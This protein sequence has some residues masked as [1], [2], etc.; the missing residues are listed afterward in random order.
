MSMGDTMLLFAVST[1]ETEARAIIEPRRIIIGTFARQMVAQQRANRSAAALD[2]AALWH[3]FRERAPALTPLEYE[4]LA[5]DLGFIEQL[6]EVRLQQLHRSNALRIPGHHPQKKAPPSDSPAVAAVFAAIRAVL[7]ASDNVTTWVRAFTTH[8][9]FHDDRTAQ[10]V[11]YDFKKVRRSATSQARSL[12]QTW[13]DTD[14]TALLRYSTYPYQHA[15]ALL[16]AHAQEAV[17]QSDESIDRSLILPELRA[18]VVCLVQVLQDAELN[19]YYQMLCFPTHTLYDESLWHQPPFSDYRKR[20]QER[21]PEDIRRIIVRAVTL[22]RGCDDSIATRLLHSYLHAGMSD[23]AAWRCQQHYPTVQLHLGRG[24]IRH[25]AEQM[26]RALPQPAQ[27]TILARLDA[28]QDAADAAKVSL[29]WYHL[30]IDV[31]GSRVR[32]HEQHKE[33]PGDFVATFATN[34]RITKE[35][36]QALL[37]NSMI[38]GPLGLLPIREWRTL[39]HPTLWSYLHLHK[40]GHL[41]GMINYPRL[42]ET[43]AAYARLLNRPPLPQQ[44]VT[45]IC[46]H[47]PKDNYF[48][49]GDGEAT[50]GVPLRKSLKLAGVA[51]LHEEWLVMAVAVEI[52]LVDHT[53][54]SRNTECIALCVFDCG[55]QR[56]VTCCVYAGP[57]SVREIG[58]TLYDA[59]WHPHN[60]A[61]PLR[62]LPEHILLPKPLAQGDLS[63]IQESAS[64]MHTNVHEV[65]PTDLKKKLT[66]HAFIKQTIADLQEEYKP[67]RR[68]GRRR[69]PRQQM[70]VMEAQTTIR[71]WLHEYGF[72]QDHRIEHEKVPRAIRDRG[73]IM[74]GFDTAVAGYLLP[75]VATDV[76][77]VRDGVEYQQFRYLNPDAEIEPGYTVTLRAL[78]HDTGRPQAV[79]AAYGNP[80]CLHYLDLV[81]RR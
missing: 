50:A 74:P 31:P 4:P 25:A 68:S 53:G 66:H 12:V 33:R 30:V 21:L 52:D 71:T 34:A 60:I 73:Y 57:V 10:Q 7:A 61:W 54:R 35:T 76:P 63:G 47:F 38:Y 51:R 6:R 45:G 78:P 43:Y 56:A 69:A 29:R 41:E 26:V 24:R 64:W 9:L 16:Q 42:T 23:L 19:K 65:S 58:L 79:F 3:A 67:A 59:I 11:A 27:Q 22:R 8:G 18:D 39:V 1:L 48:N 32:R 13:L 37:K 46:N 44:M 36:A 20:Y 75:I 5:R 70:T 28:L 49:S 17:R 62:G 2:S 81:G 72:T 14:D 80:P 55:S 77:T 15:L 40:L